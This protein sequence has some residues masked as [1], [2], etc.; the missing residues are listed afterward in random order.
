MNRP[1]RQHTEDLLNKLRARIPGLA[2]RTTFICGFPGVSICH[3]MLFCCSVAGATARANSVKSRQHLCFALQ[4]TEEQHQE[5]VEFCT[6]FKFERMG[7]FTYSAEE[8]TPA[9]ELPAQVRIGPG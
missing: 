2:L 5:L 1:P 7:A 3:M 8:G 4:E 6:R 9:A